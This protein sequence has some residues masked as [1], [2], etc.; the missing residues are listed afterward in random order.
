MPCVYAALVA[1]LPHL[2][3][4]AFVARFGSESGS[5]MTAIGTVVWKDLSTEAN[6][7]TYSLLYLASP[8]AQSPAFE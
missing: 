2:G 3:L 4:P 8:S 7:S 1:E 5:M 6:L